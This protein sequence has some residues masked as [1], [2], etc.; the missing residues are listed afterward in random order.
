[1]TAQVAPV[2]PRRSCIHRESPRRTGW[3]HPPPVP[4]VVETPEESG[5]EY[6]RMT[7]EDLAPQGVSEE[8]LIRH[9]S[10]QRPM[11]TAASG[12]ALPSCTQTA[13]GPG[14]SRI[15]SDGIGTTRALRRP[16]KC[17]LA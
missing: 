5:D 6:N 1:M 12:M 9:A 2:P 14:P 16:S 11:S 10:L 4:V 15:T 7:E 8:A 17:P 13:V 3:P